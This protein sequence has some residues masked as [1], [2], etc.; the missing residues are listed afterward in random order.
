MACDELSKACQKV[1]RFLH[2][3]ALVE[4]EI[5]QRIADILKLKGDAADVVAYTVAFRKKVDMLQIVALETAP[6]EE[7]KGIKTLI[8]AIDDQNKNRNL[9]AHCSFKPAKD[10]AVQ[11]K[12]TVATGGKV[13]VRDPL[14]TKLQFE[15]ASAKLK[16]IQEEL[17]RLKPRRGSKPRISTRH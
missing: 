6:S 7:K 17:G 1:G 13:K 16:K 9:M 4:Q 12:S 5:N 11:F 10:E 8:S 3:F 15:Q 2:D 14:W